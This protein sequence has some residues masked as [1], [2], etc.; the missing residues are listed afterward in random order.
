ML[1]EC[2][3]CVL[4]LPASH[5]VDDFKLSRKFSS[6]AMFKNWNQ[7]WPQKLT[8]VLSH[9]LVFH[10]FQLDVQSC[11]AIVCLK[12]WWLPV[13]AHMINILVLP[14]KLSLLVFLA[15]GR[16][17]PQLYAVIEA[18]FVQVDVG[19]EHVTCLSVLADLAKQF[20]SPTTVNQ[21]MEEH[22]VHKSDLTPVKP[23]GVVL[24]ESFDDIRAGCFRYV[25]ASGNGEKSV[26]ETCTKQPFSLS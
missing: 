15:S 25:T 7:K 2:F 3:C 13:C 1:S 16:G 9:V 19:Q 24:F 11:F 26:I 18:G 22:C 10:F 20:F 23:E 8:C 14:N 21:E 5:T 4:N 12:T 6:D 17:I